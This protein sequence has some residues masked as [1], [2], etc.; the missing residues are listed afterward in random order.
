MRLALIDADNIPFVIGHKYKDFINDSGTV[1]KDALQDILP[2]LEQGV[3]TYIRSILR[4]TGAK[5]YI[6]VLSNG[7]KT[8]R[9]IHYSYAPYK[10]NRGPKPDWY[11]FWE[12]YILSRLVNHWGFKKVPVYGETLSPETD[13]IIAVLARF[14]SGENTQDSRGFE[15]IIC[16]PDKDMLQ[17]PGLHYNH[18]KENPD[19][20]PINKEEAELI[21]LQQVLMGDSTDNI[22]GIPGMGEVKAA[23]LLKDA[24]QFGTTFVELVAKVKEQYLK[25]FGGYYGPIIYKETC[26]AVMLLDP[27]NHPFWNDYFLDLLEHFDS[28]WYRDAPQEEE[29]PELGI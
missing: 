16:S 1:D 14:H 4:G 3:D 27:I 11:N 28:S 23:K 26:I 22:A 12:P 25:S 15:P 8:F 13:D 6:G 7:E 10:G 24:A 21:L 19:V 17:I 9:H 2:L 5:M 20:Y 18:G 29:L